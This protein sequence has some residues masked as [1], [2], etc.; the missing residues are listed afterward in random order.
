MKKDEFKKANGGQFR[1]LNGGHKNESFKVTKGNKT[2]FFK[3]KNFDHFNH[4]IDYIILNDFDFVPKLLE[5][6]ADSLQREW[7]VGKT[8]KMVVENLT[9]ISDILKTVHNSKLK[10]PK[11]NHLKRTTAY[12]K[13]LS[14][15]KK[16]PE[17]IYKYNEL[18]IKIAK[19][20]K[21]LVPLHNDPWVNNLIKNTKENKIYLIDWEYA[22]MG[23]KH[24]DLAFFIEGSH[25]TSNQ[26][27]L[28]LERYQNYDPI[29]LKEMKFFV[30]YLTL[31]WMHRLDELPF[32]DEDIIMKLNKLYDEFQ[33]SNK[34]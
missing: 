6:D 19:S 12:F 34:K 15:H 18:A 32:S 25:L 5:Q 9:K 28:F 31:V 29:R 26:E 33:R 3:E 1:K 10:F 4:E 11:S 16:G 22:T 14:I 20:I 30:N 24:F 21:N 27:V 2:F 23:D 17:E 8:P 13:E 7:I